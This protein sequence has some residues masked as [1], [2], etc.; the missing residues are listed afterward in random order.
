M[1]S[2]NVQFFF[3]IHAYII[4][5]KHIKV[6]KHFQKPTFCTNKFVKN[7]K[8]KRQILCPKLKGRSN[9]EEKYEKRK[10]ANQKQCK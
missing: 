9:I 3:L 7:A 4:Y 6:N 1:G 2:I 5:S 8:K 10:N